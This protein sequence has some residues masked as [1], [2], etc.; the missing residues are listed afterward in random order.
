MTGGEILFLSLVIGTFTVFGL[1]L[2]W[3]NTH[4]QKK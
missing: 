1:V 3:A 2:A 4:W